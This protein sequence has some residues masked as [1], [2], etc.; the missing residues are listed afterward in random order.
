[1]NENEISRIIVDAA[2]EVRREVGGSGDED[3][4]DHHALSCGAG[5]D[6]PQSGGDGQMRLTPFGALFVACIVCSNFYT[7]A[8]RSPWSGKQV[9]A[10]CVW[11]AFSSAWWCWRRQTFVAVKEER[12]VG[13]WRNR[14]CPMDVRN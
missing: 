11:K 10:L 2:I 8:K 9:E 13:V 1:M 14:L 4:H 3:E 5:R 7:L 6:R 12:T